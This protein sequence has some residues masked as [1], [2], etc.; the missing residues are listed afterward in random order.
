MNRPPVTPLPAYRPR[1]RCRR[2]PRDLP[3]R[4]AHTIHRRT[5][6]TKNY[7][8]TEAYLEF[9]LGMRELYD[10]YC[11]VNNRIPQYQHK[12]LF[13]SKIRHARVTFVCNN[14]NERYNV[15]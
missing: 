3:L 1:Q 9:F 6:E 2:R 12:H 4:R 11:Y 13:S 14:N 15:V 8:H 10:F 7:V 5:T